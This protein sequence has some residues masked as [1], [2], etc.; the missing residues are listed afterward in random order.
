MGP[1]FL[2]LHCMDSCCTKLELWNKNVFGHVGKNITKLKKQLEWLELQLA[3]TENIMAM[4]D[5]RVELNCW[6]DKEDSI[7]HQRSRL[8]WFQVR[9]RSTSYFHSKASTRFQKNI[10]KGLLDHNETLQENVILV[11]KKFITKSPVFR[12]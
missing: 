8:N 1:E 10:I 5:T 12:H 2:I 7:W 4:R 3:T 11:T 9:D 6:L